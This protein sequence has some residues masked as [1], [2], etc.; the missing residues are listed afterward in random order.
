MEYKMVRKRKITI[1]IALS[2]TLLLGKPRSS[3]SQP[4]S[5]NF[6]NREIHEKVILAKGKGNLYIPHVNP[7]RIAPKLVGPELPDSVKFRYNLETIIA[8]KALKIV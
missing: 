1:W 7:Y 2:L 8:K 4:S 6:N 5:P 3:S